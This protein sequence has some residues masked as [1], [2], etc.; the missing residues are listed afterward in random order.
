MPFKCACFIS[1]PHNAGKSVDKFVTRLKEELQDKFAQFV[2]DPIVTDHDF[3]TGAHFHQVIAQQI[4][5]SAC[6]IVVYMPVYQRKAF[7]IQEYTAMQRL[8]AQR[9]D[10]LAAKPSIPIGMIL[11]IVYTGEEAKIPKW[12]SGQIN[13]RNISKFTISDPLSVF[14][15]EDFKT[16]LVQMANLVDSLYNTFQAANAN[17]C[18]PCG[19]YALPA[20]TD[21]DVIAKLNVPTAPTESF[22]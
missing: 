15:D 20:E 1:Y 19:T 8:E 3:P 17:P 11:P 22:R 16:W 18:H 14:D 10:A 21:P 13:Y 2:T 5:Q 6:L 12:I 4:C 9:Y 7:C